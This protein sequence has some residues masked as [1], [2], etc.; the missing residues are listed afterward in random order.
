MTAGPHIRNLF[1]RIVFTKSINKNSS[2]IISCVHS[3]DTI[4]RRRFK[5]FAAR[6]KIAPRVPVLPIQTKFNS[7]LCQISNFSLRA[8]LWVTESWF[9]WPRFR[10]SNR[11]SKRKSLFKSQNGRVPRGTLPFFDLESDLGIRLLPYIVAGLNLVQYGT[12]ERASPKFY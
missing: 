8:H 2:A 12:A 4:F 1:Y 10:N 6:A 11:N 3:L 9:Q 5:F 7:T